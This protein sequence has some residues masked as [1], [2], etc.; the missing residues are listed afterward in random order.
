MGYRIGNYSRAVL[1]EI[2]GVW[3]MAHVC[4]QEQQFLCPSGAVCHSLK[5]L[6]T[7]GRYLAEGVSQ[8]TKSFSA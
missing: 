8:K 7:L 4:T 3:T 2:L 1:K 6:G 5:L